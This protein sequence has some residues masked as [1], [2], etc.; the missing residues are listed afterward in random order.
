MSTEKL[1]S[2]AQA[3]LSDMDI[4]INGSNPWDIQIHNDDFYARVLRYGSLG[5]GESYMEKWWDCKQLDQFFEHL[6]KG[7]IESKVKANKWRLTHLLLPLILNFQTKKRALEVGKKHYDLGNTLYQWMLDKG[8]N[9]SE[10]YWENAEDLEEAQRDKMALIC[11]KLKLKAGMRLLDVGCGFGGL[12]KYA[13]EHY[14]V[15]AVG[16]TISQKQYE[17]AKKIC[18]HLP[19]DIRFQDYRDLNEKFDRIASLGMFEHV[20][21]KN[22]RT[23]MQKI[24]QCLEDNGLFLMRTIGN[25][26]T[27]ISNDEWLNKYIF[28]NSMIPSIAQIGKATEGLLLMKEWVN[29]SSDYDKTL[30]VWYDNFNAHWEE[31][32]TEYDERFYRMWHYYLLSCAGIFRAQHMQLWQIVFSKQLVM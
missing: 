3:L 16:I 7:N 20:G 25:V 2:Y 6:L 32:K 5:L 9:Y 12:V 24:H 19:V 27:C 30:M 18:A 1:K 8:M 21:P 31:L 28:P 22:Y 14:G 29:R 10:G 13:A 17:Y 26:A 4:Q 23:Y 15:S 11:Q